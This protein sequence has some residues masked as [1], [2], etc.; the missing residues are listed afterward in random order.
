MPR[1]VIHDHDGHVD[2]LLSCILLWLS[3]E[4]DLQAVGITNG[5]CYAP[6]IFEATQK[7]ATF[8]DIE[9]P[10]IAVTED[11]VPNPFPDNWRRESYIINELPL[12]EDNYLKKTYQQGRPRR[13]DSVFLDCIANSKVPITVVTTGPLT[14]MA[15]LL[16]NHPEIKKNIQEF[17]IMGGA[18]RVKGNVEEP[19]HDGTAEWNVYADPSA[20]KQIVDSKLPIKL[21]TLDLTNELPVTKDFLGKLEAQAE[22]SR[23]S[24]LAAKLWSLVKGFDY[25]FWDTITAAVA[26]E[27]GLFTFSDIKID[28]STS[29]KSMGRTNQ[30]LFGRKVQLATQVNKQGFEDLLLS[31][32]SIR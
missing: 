21:I 31:T 26:I 24:A 27:P 10:E 1:T 20:F 17:I 4:I 16:A 6:Q 5:D 28:V 13:I 23:A 14:N 7:I 22:K 15:N 29:G 2:D 32:L 9:G 8:L 19:G 18:I 12:F 11:E 30:A 3:P 25:Y